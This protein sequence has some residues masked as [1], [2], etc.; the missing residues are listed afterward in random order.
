MKG[1]II[2]EGSDASGKTTLANKLLRKYNGII[3][4]QTYRFKNN[5]PI[6][7]MAIL[8]KAL[9]LSKTQLVILDRLHISEYI[10]GKVFRNE[11]RW[12]WMLNSF[13]SFCKKM[14]IPIILCI[15]SSVEEGKKWFEE[16]KNKRYEMFDDM[17][18]ILEEYIKYAENHKEVIIYNRDLCVEYHSWYDDYTYAAIENILNKED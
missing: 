12:P 5:I 8:R 14:N 15:P 3:F 17:T 11:T 10:Y 6:Y 16:T 18:K 2:I 1:I 7:H 4:H 9:K 13:N